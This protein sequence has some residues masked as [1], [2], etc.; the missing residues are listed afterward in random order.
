[1]IS[2]QRWFTIRVGNQ[3]WPSFSWYILRSTSLPL[4][5]GCGRN[6]KS[7]TGLCTKNYREDLMKSHPKFLP[8]LTQN[9][10][11]GFYNCPQKSN[12][13]SLCRDEDKAIIQSTLV[14]CC[15]VSREWNRIF[16]PIL[17]GDIF[18]G[19]KKTRATRSLLHRTFR[20]TK[21]THKALVRKMTIE[22]AE[23]GSAASSLSICFSL[24]NLHKLIIDLPEVD[25]ATL[26][27]NFAQ[28]LLSLSRCCAVQIRG[29][30][31]NNNSTTQ[32]QSLPIWINFFRRSRSIPYSLFA[33]AS[34]GEYWILFIFQT[35]PI[36]H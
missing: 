8:E 24:P 4:Q 26:H 2:K 14:A 36:H 33:D 32:W 29:D 28:N 9:I 15:L 10:L 19:G 17:Y 21:P 20:H 30:R 13:H 7:D 31:S 6:Q 35:R 18:L 27:P 5:N 22:L 1:M 34:G 11:P 23:D 12:S 16:T 3:E 25:P